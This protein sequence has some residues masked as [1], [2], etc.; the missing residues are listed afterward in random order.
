MMEIP[1]SFPVDRL[2]LSVRVVRAL[3]KAGVET[4]GQIPGDFRLIDIPG[5]GYGGSDEIE[6]LRG[7]AACSRRAREDWL[8]RE[9][10]SYRNV[11]SAVGFIEY[12]ESRGEVTQS[13]A[14]E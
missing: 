1:E 8:D 4:F 5:I 10:R 2:P 13:A 11:S 7:V 6:T 9:E 12:L 14:A 3:K